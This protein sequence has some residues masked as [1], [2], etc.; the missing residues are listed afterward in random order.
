[1]LFSSIAFLFYFL[2]ISLLL[3]YG[4]SFSKSLKNIVL[5][6]L[7]LVFYAWGEPRY[8]FVMII[9]ILLN[10]ILGV[11]IDK[12]RRKKDVAK[13][14]VVLSIV[15]NLGI[16]FVF[17]YLGFLVRTI[18]EMQ[19]Y[20]FTIP[21]ISLPIG[22]SFFTLRAISYVVD[23]YKKEGVIQNNPIYAGLYMAFFSQVT[24]GPIERY[25][26][27]IEQIKDREESWR[28]FGVGCCRV[29]TGLGKKVM[30]ANS[31]AIIVDRIFQM[32][33]NG[34]VPVT[35]AWLGILAYALQIFFDF[36]AY[37]DIAIGLGLMFG[38]KCD[39]NFRYP[40]VSKS[41]SEFWRRWHISLGSWLREYIYFP[42]GGS[43]VANKDKIIRN[44]LIVWV[45][46][47]VWHGAE[48]TF[49]TW[50]IFNFILIAAEKLLGFDTIKGFDR[51]KHIYVLFFVNL[52]WVL[53][54][55]E[56]LIEAGKY[57]SC[58]FGLSN[59]GF[60]SDYTYMFI[61]ENLI[62]FLAAIILSMPISRRVN[63]FL[64]QK[65]KFYKLFEFAYPIAMIL[66]FLISM[67]YITKGINNT[68]IYF[69]F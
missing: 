51:L 64:I 55:A 30:I 49:I 41:I 38:F 13:N 61:R 47:G 50:G 34:T 32:N 20:K 2:P 57:F 63:K 46:T 52:G 19:Q 18:N 43:K 53:F 48:W 7:S 31:M 23:V 35:L 25:S 40:Y 69:N 36:S 66:L 44:L 16:L 33:S 60:W 21:S 65:E 8:V 29:I 5:M 9:S 27:M 45:L 15:L 1:M 56:N 4:V 22:I 37:S 3:Y 62:F 68:F 39:E 67:S 11:L 17:K 24:A 14:I 26:N 6:M 12:F 10:Y 59:N 54:R 58:M 42:L 28:K